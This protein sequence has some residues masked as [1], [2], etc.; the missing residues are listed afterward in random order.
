MTSATFFS[1][2]HSRPSSL[3]RSAACIPA[4]ST[5]PTSL[6]NNDSCSSRMSARMKSSSAE[7]VSFS[8]RRADSAIAASLRA[9]SSGTTAGS[10]S[11]GAGGRPTR[12]AAG[13]SGRVGTNPRSSTVRSA[14]P[15][16]GS[17]L[18]IIPTMPGPWVGEASMGVTST[19]SRP[20]ACRMG[21]RLVNCHTEIP[22]GFSG[23]VIICW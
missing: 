4:A 23:S 17:E 3:S 15:K 22:N 13:S 1:P 7:P 12:A 19:N 18:P 2:S 21:A 6:P 5:S 10:I 8:M 11:S 20:P 9:T 14:S 16:S